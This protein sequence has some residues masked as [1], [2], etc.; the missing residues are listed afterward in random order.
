MLRNLTRFAATKWR[1]IRSTTTCRSRIPAANY[2][3]TVTVA[4]GASLF[5]TA[6]GDDRSS[7]RL[8]GRT[9]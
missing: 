3:V 8:S 9:G 5:A 4:L 6:H 7:W 1:A 2:R